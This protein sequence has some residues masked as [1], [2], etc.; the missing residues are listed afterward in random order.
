[1]ARRRWG[2]SWRLDRSSTTPPERPPLACAGRSANTMRLTALDEAAEGFGL[3][4][5]QGLAEARAICAGLDVLEAD[6]A[7]DRSF[8]DA[9]ADWC[10][11]YTPLVALDGEDGL[12]LDI[13]G[14]A[15]LFGGEAKLVED[16]DQRLT[17][18]GL[19]VHISVASTPGL[20]RACS[21]FGGPTLVS[22]P[23][24]IRVLS[25]LPVAA[26]RLDAGT[27]ANLARVGLKTV[28]DLI[29]APRP[30]ITR[31]FGPVPI[32][33]LDQA[34]GHEGEPISPRRMLPLLSAE[35]R[36]AEPIVSEDH[37]LDLAG[38]LAGGL[39]TALEARGEGGRLFELLVFRV[40][41]RV[42]RIE[43]GA[44]APLRDPVRIRALF[45]ERLGV[46]ADEL[47]AG[48]GYELL[49]LNVLLSE[50]FDIRQAALAEDEGA[51][52]SELL[53]R[54]LDQ[55]TA[56]LGERALR[57]PVPLASH[58]PDRAATHAPLTDGL[59]ALGR[60]LVGTR[61][62][63]SPRRSPRPIRLLDRPE[64]VEVMSSVPDGPPASFRWRRVQRRIARAEGPERLAPE[65]WT[66]GEDAPPRDYFRIEDT[67]GQR[68][69]L[70]RE[71]LFE[72]RTVNPTW[73]LQGFF[74]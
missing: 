50:A 59:K 40:D 32:L 45:R 8:L 28:G 72:R 2:L 57:L 15:H 55:V 3:R 61:D 29:A 54:F 51:E 35:R 17:A 53:T 67:A 68:F 24:A 46:L 60:A 34:L 10:D 64:E 44:S 36:L 66:D 9:I 48:F 20:A 13:S 22:P 25:P 18:F 74:S 63:A 39:K 27:L 16:L 4:V 73:F 47:D 30:P 31:R 7:A 23:D 62:I 56:R 43:V 58:W 14:C 11:R 42:F 65:W 1:M 41:G 38:R 71:G 33:R 5:G 26:L 52:A 37:V 49:R 21:R 19:A 12:L 69:W 6:P 70:Y